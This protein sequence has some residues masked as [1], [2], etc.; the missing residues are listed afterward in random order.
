MI[1]VHSFRSDK[2]RP[3]LQSIGGPAMV[4]PMLQIMALS[5]ATISK[6]HPEFV[7]ITDDAGKEMAEACRLP[8]SEIV[9]VGENFDSDPCFWV[10]SKLHAYSMMDSPFVHFDTDI[11]LWEQ[12]PEDYLSSLVFAFHTEAFSWPVY[13]RYQENLQK[14]GF[15]LPK[16]GL[17]WWLNKAPLNMAV[18]GGN[19]VGLKAI[20]RYADMILRAVKGHD[21]FRNY[22]ESDKAVVDESLPYI[23]QAQASFFIQGSEGLKAELLL[24]ENQAV[25]GL[26]V[27]GVRITHLQAFK[28]RAMREGKTLDLMLRLQKKLK[29]VNEDV[30]SAVEDFTKD[31]IYEVESMLGDSND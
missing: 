4:K 25:N 20:N 6:H 23:E 30:S 26:E 13:E 29:E 3:W 31:A 9:S 10:H 18:F 2:I 24:T 28:Q 1:A 12:L 11:F 27:P 14:I 8:Y 7:L 15:V 21:G 16:F 5:S 19:G 22:S 17:N